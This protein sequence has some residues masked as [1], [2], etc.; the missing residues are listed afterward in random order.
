[1]SHILREN[2][3][4]ISGNPRSLQSRDH[5]GI[6]SL[7]RRGGGL[8]QRPGHRPRLSVGIRRRQNPRRCNRRFRGDFRD[9]ENRQRKRH[10]RRRTGGARRR[11]RV[12]LH[13]HAGERRHRDK[14]N[15]RLGYRH[16]RKR[17]GKRIA[18]TDVVGHGFVFRGSR[19]LG[20]TLVIP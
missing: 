19:N 13:R 18:P 8:P 11:L 5:Q 9:G 15:R 7:Q 12:D 14:Q 1:M 4:G 16:A 6:D 20:R 2:G 17:D 3:Y 10:G